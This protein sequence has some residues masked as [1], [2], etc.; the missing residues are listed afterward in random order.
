[1]GYVHA[2]NIPYCMNSTQT[3]PGQM[4]YGEGGKEDKAVVESGKQHQN[5]EVNSD[6]AVSLLMNMSNMATDHNQK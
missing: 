6:E 2:S 4:T 3:Q 1:M 5:T